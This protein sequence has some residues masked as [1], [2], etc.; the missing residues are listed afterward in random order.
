MIDDSIV[1]DRDFAISREYLCSMIL[2]MEQNR[3]TA[4]VISKLK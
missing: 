4:R 2:E 3:D 1:R